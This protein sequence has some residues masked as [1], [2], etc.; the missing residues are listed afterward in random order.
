VYERGDGSVPVEP[1]NGYLYLAPAKRLELETIAFSAPPP[2]LTPSQRLALRWLKE[3]A[4]P[5]ATIIDCGCGS[6]LFLRALRR[7]GLRGV[8]VEVSA[9]LVEMLSRRGMEAREGTVEDF[10]W[11]GDPP[12][13]ITFFE[14]LEHFAEPAPMIR[15]ILKRFP[16]TVMLAS[17]PS[18]TR[19][20]LLFRGE[21]SPSDFPPN[22]FVRWTPR[23]LEIFFHDQG[24]RRVTI[25]V[26]PP[27][28]SELLPGLGQLLR[29]SRRRMGDPA[30]GKGSVVPSLSRRIGVTA[31]LWLHKA[32]QV[33][34]DVIGALSARRAGRKGGS[35]SSM[36]VVAE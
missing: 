23:A 21:R 15:G 18:P 20:R 3:R 24:F 31:L 29:R 13:A 1:E 11:E 30:A 2:R 26:P 12:F 16:R 9:A 7:A 32:W 5:G 33:G 35:A 27:P 8:G 4:A 14:V 34:A 19:A 28:G 10:P 6:G 17:V 36:L 22:H 25:S